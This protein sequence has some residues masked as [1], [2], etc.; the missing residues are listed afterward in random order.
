VPTVKH[1]MRT[2]FFWIVN[3]EASV[4]VLSRRVQF[5][6]KGRACPCCVMSL[7]AK[8]RVILSLRYLKKLIDVLACRGCLPSL[9][10]KE[11]KPPESFEQL[12]VFAKLLTQFST[13]PV[14]MPMRT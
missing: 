10:V 2:V 5:A 9:V 6:E 13:S 4:H 14:A 1:S 3:G 12:S 7:Q 8:G 11:P